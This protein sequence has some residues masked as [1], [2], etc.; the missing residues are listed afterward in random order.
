MIGWAW[1][2]LAF[3]RKHTRTHYAELVFL[4]LVRFVS[5]V[6]HSGASGVENIDALFF[7]LRWPPCGLHKKYVVT[8][9]TNLVFL[10]PVGSAGQVVHSGVVSIKS[11]PGHV[12]PNLYFCIRSD[13][14]VT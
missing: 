7:M 5:D 9:Y 2:A 8:R 1:K 12:T 6:V 3:D 13:L 10:R 11:A 4:H 14:R